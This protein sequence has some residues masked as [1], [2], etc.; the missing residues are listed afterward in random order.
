MAKHTLKAAVKADI[1][2]ET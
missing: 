2:Q 1:P